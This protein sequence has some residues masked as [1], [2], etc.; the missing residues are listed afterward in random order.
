MQSPYAAP[1]PY[2]RPLAAGYGGQFPAWQPQIVPPDKMPRPAYPGTAQQPFGANRCQVCSSDN[3]GKPLKRYHDG[4]LCNTCIRS[5]LW[6]RT[7]AFLLDALVLVGFIFVAEIII[8]LFLF[9]IP[10]PDEVTR[11]LVYFFEYLVVTPYLIGKD[12]WFKGR[13]IGKAAS[14]VTVVNVETNYPITPGQSV[15]RNAIL[16]AFL[17][18]FI[19]LIGILSFWLGD[20]PV[21]AL[22]VLLAI[23]VALALEIFLFLF[24]P[25]WHGRRLGEKWAGTRV[26]FTQLPAFAHYNLYHYAHI[27]WLQQ[28]SGAPQ[29]S[30]AP[31]EGNT[32][33]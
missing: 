13:S 15:K 4:Y 23:P 27:L 16:Y 11:F 21:A 32:F 29:P 7:G 19:M 18:Q 25:F 3:T 33:G 26:I 17:F 20:L 22:L 31:G 9:A 10:V 1:P 14:G 24:L 28:Q 2:A 30:P 6:K 8:N 12:A 5:I